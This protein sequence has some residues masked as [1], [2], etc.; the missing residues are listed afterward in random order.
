MSTGAA[1]CAAC[2]ARR[3]G[4]PPLR[5]LPLP[6]PADRASAL[7]G[8]M[9]EYLG[10]PD[11]GGHDTAPNCRLLMLAPLPCFAP[12]CLGRRKEESWVRKMKLQGELDAKRA[13]AAASAH[14]K[15]AKEAGRARER[16][17]EDRVVAQRERDAA[18][19]AQAEAEGAMREVGGL[20]RV[21][22]Q[23][24]RSSA[25]DA[26]L[27]VRMGWGWAVGW[28]AGGMPPACRHS[29][30]W[31]GHAYLRSRPSLSRSLTVLSS[32]V[33]RR[34]RSETTSWLERQR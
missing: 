2:L 6:R 33:C 10:V 15:A 31:T 24:S 28:A 30:W 13:L 27:C 17:E 1:G 14:E 25:A 8:H 20:R 7:I 18:L 9:V 32:F 21:Q 3:G 19:A 23:R 22:E 34:L 16:A 29:W 12:P 5:W 4:R 11:I 26:A